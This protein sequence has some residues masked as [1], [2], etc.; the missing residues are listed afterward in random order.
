MINNT[1]AEA[2]DTVSNN[3]DEISKKIQ[4]E[5]QPAIGQ[6]AAML[7]VEDQ[8]SRNAAANFSPQAINKSIEI[9]GTSDQRN[10][11]VDPRNRQALV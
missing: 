8:A 10:Y 1:V 11:A 7:P 5:Q 3:L 6:S 4:I 9:N 2:P